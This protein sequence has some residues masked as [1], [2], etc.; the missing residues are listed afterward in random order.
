MTSNAIHVKNVA[1]IGIYVSDLQAAVSFYVN[2]M[3][4]E[5]KGCIGPGHMLALGEAS[6]YLEGG[7]SKNSEKQKMKEADITVCFG[8]ESVK[9]AYDAVQEKGVQIVMKY[10][11][12]GPEY[13]V[14]MVTDPDGN[15]I[16]IAGSP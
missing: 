7:R 4:L 11:E 3:G 9:S 10:T 16:E 8:V 2:T 13:A 1:V 12:Y 15:I 5:D 14:F 6:F